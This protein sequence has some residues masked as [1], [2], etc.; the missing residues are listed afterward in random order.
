MQLYIVNCT[1]F[2][3]MMYLICIWVALC[4]IHGTWYISCVFKSKPEICKLMSDCFTKCFKCAQTGKHSI[5]TMQVWFWDLCRCVSGSGSTSSG[6]GR[7]QFHWNNCGWGQVWVLVLSCRSCWACFQPRQ[8][9][10]QQV[11]NVAI[12]LQHHLVE[13]MCIQVCHNIGCLLGNSHLHKI[14]V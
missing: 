10:T 14:I 11:P 5:F 9:S 7:V 1:L 6:S 3:D 2:C 8:G 13:K 4:I 12:M